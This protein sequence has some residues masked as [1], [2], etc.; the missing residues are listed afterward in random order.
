MSNPRRRSFAV[1][2]ALGLVGALALSACAE[3]AAGDQSGG[4]GVSF[5]ATKE[6]YQEA[7]ADVE[8]ISLFTQSPA[9]KGS[10]VGKNFEDY[11]SAIEEWSD[12]K[13]T[14]D[15]SWSN[16]TAA[17]TEVDDAL[18]D[19]RLDVGSVMAGYEPDL[20]PTY[21]ALS[22]TSYMGNGNPLEM[23]MA[24]HGYITD[25]VNSDGAVDDEFAARGMK[26]LAPAFTGGINGIFCSDARRDLDSLAGAQVRISGSAH[27]AEAKALGMSPV[28]LDYAEV[29]EALQ[30]GVLDCAYAGAT[31]VLLGDLLSVAPH[32][33]LDSKTS[34]GQVPSAL[35]ISQA[36]W[37]ELPLVAQQLMY[38]RADVF[39][40]SNMEGLLDMYRQ[41][42]ELV[43]EKN[44][45][46]AGLD[47]AAQ[48][49]LDK[50]NEEFLNAV[51]DNKAIQDGSALVEAIRSG[52]ETWKGKVG[53]LGYD[54]EVDY[55]DLP[56]YLAE[57]EVDFTAFMD[58]WREVAKT[59]RPS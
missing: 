35:A 9:P 47:E 45:T 46:I 44:G 17:P 21:A 31:V 34:F 4:E 12:G 57:N 55:A 41:V 15:I 6:E 26:V 28:S 25:I 51:A 30:R 32:V 56:A 40:L 33:I 50:G 43:P 11:F 22:D 3:D 53:E 24:P 29:Y 19:G 8:P 58:A 27:A 13:I 5:G 20:Y 1:L 18:A 36:K 37:D 59:S 23:V 16:A 7:F 49:E 10:P 14:F 42:L 2:G 39:V 52:S 48:S 54:T 38:D